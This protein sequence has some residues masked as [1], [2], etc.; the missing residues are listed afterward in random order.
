[1]NSDSTS[2]TLDQQTHFH[3]TAL[4]TLRSKLTAYGN[5]ISPDHEVALSG[6]CELAAMN[7]FGGFEK[8]VYFALP[9]GMGKT[10]GVRAILHATHELGLPYRV[11]VASSKVEEL[12]I[13]KRTLIADGIPPEK[14]GLLHSYPC[15]RDR[16][17]TGQSGFASEPAGNT[18]APF[19]LVTHANVQSGADKEWMNRC[20]LVLFDESLIVGKAHCLPLY[21]DS[22]SYA[23]SV[24][25][26][27]A[28]L[29]AFATGRESQLLPAAKAARTLYDQLLTSA[30]DV[31]SA[32]VGIVQASC[33]D[34]PS[35]R[36]ARTALPPEADRFPLVRKLFELAENAAELRAFTSG[37]DRTTLITYSVSVPD[38]LRNVIV[39]DASGPIRELVHHDR[40][41]ERAE[42]VVPSLARF[43][44]MPGGLASIK[45]HSAVQVHFACVGGGRSTLTA[46][47]AEPMPW[48]LEKLKRLI[49]SKPG[50]SFLV[51]TYKTRGQ[52]TDFSR[53][54]IRSLVEGGIDPD[55]L[56]P[57]GIAEAPAVRRVQLTTWGRETGTNEFSAYQNVVLLG[58]VRKPVESVA[59]VYLGQVD[60]LRCPAMKT[61]VRRLV[62]SECW[63][64]IYQAINRCRMRRVHV[65]DGVSQAMPCSVYIWHLDSQLESKLSPVLRGCPDWQPWKEPDETSTAADIAMRIRGLLGRMEAQGVESITCRALR[66][67]VG[68]V[69]ASTFLRGRRLALADSSWVMTRATITRVAFPAAA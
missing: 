52:G 19:L 36:A 45:Y 58:A 10:T 48:M 13:L 65:V 18:D 62:D 60:D 5:Q 63:H 1:M 11:V 26:E 49:A 39:L 9:C 64:S 23:P 37:V 32:P 69:P 51:V 55:E 6:L 3:A 34:A 22:E 66:K 41:M 68:Q 46:R 53:R 16:V 7:L 30:K 47:I 17:L 33:I 38:R 35:I 27:L 44:S 8:R 29:E 2:R 56:V 21:R 14:I 4:N 59:G 57:T 24:F 40:R 54:A 67:M 15:S 20:D 50:E 43:A 31:R 25:R 61:L 28:T 12:C 42:D